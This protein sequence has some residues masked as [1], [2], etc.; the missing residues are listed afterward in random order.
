MLP[1]LLQAGAAATAS[2]AAAGEREQQSLSQQ[3]ERVL[4]LLV[5]YGGDVWQLPVEDRRPG[6]P[7]RQVSGSKPAT[8]FCNLSRQQL[9]LCLFVAVVGVQPPFA[10]PLCSS[11]SLFVL[12]LSFSASL[13][14]TA[15]C[16]HFLPLSLSLFPLSLRLALRICLAVSLCLSLS[17]CLFQCPVLSV[18]LIYVSSRLQESS[19][20]SLSVAAMGLCFIF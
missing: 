3:P 11:L 6:Q 10:A 16:R 14:L 20:A 13:S 4:L 7:M 2:S 17:A 1:P 18:S 9:S 12:P 8:S 15:L 5:N 19:A